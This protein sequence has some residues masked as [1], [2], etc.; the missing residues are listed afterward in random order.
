MNKNQA[1][2]PSLVELATDLHGLPDARQVARKTTAW[3]TDRFP[4]AEGILL[5]V[6]AGDVFATVGVY[7]YSHYPSTMLTPLES[8]YGRLLNQNSTVWARTPEDVSALPLGVGTGEFES[9]YAQLNAMLA[10]LPN[11]S[12]VIVPCAVSGQILGSISVENWSLPRPFTRSD[13]QVFELVGRLAALALD[14]CQKITIF[15][16]RGT[17]TVWRIN[18]RDLTESQTDFGSAQVGAKQTLV[19]DEVSTQRHRPPTLSHETDGYSLE[20]DDR[21]GNDLESAVL[22]PRELTVLRLI[23]QGMTNNDIAERLVI[24]PNTVRSHRRAILSKLKAHNIL[25]AI[26]RAKDLRLL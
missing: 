26:K 23:A 9:R 22:S 1:L 8:E 24:S 18:P 20:A 10:P 12:C 15:D 7:G 21:L 11:R 2:A 5:N 4:A 13:V 25:L 14:Y 6:R 19:S 17:T 3:L 16:K